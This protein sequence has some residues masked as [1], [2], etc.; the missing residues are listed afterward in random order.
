M[1][2]RLVK[3]AGDTRL[4]RVDFTNK[5]S[6]SQT[7]QNKVTR[8]IENRVL[9]VRKFLKEKSVLG[10][11]GSVAIRD[12]MKRRDD[13]VIPATRTITNILKRNGQTDKRNR[14]RRKPPQEGWYLPDLALRKVELDSFDIVEKLYLY[15]GLEVQFFNG[16]SL[17]GSLVTS[18]P[19]NV[20]RSETAIEMLVKHWKQ[21]N[22]PK[23]A[24][25]DNDMIFQG[26]RRKNVVGKVIRMCLSLG[27]IPVF[28]TPYEQGFQGKIERFNGELQRC[29][30]RRK[31]FKNINN[32]EQHLKEWIVEYNIAQQ[33]KI[34]AAPLRR[35]FPKN[36]KRNDTSPLKGKIIYLRRTDGEGNVWILENKFYVSE[37]WINRL[38]RAELNI[39]KNI[40]TFYALRRSEPNKQKVLKVQKFN[41]NKIKNV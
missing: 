4:G 12:E 17:H 6:G 33:E 5:K 30:W 31:T 24:Q 32:V 15:G 21:F 1:V 37:H 8:K 14:V 2:H 25:F 41:I 20:I 11:H 29:F 13:K 3:L 40:I 36:W 18:S 16:I 19:S 26:A 23:Y 10:W 22:L 34:L 7:P 39:D 27:V 38:V 35:T 9:S 28:A